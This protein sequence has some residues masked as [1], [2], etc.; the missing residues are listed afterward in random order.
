MDNPIILQFVTAKYNEFS[1]EELTALF[2][3]AM[4]A[5]NDCDGIS[6]DAYHSLFKSID[7]ASRS[8]RQAMIKICERLSAWIILYLPV[9]A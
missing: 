9:Q 5:I 1:G 3:D 7:G 4:E 8:S 2:N 6:V